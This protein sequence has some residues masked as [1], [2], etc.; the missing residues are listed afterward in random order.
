MPLLGSGF[1]F[2]VDQMVADNNDQ[3]EVEIAKL[4][5]EVAALRALLEK[6]EAAPEAD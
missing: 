2:V 5:D 6:R 3:V 1:L 4:T